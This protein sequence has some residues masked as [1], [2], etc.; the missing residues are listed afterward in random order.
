MHVHAESP[1][2]AIL[3]SFRAR[4]AQREIGGAVRVDS[5]A[6]RGRQHRAE[7]R[8]DVVAVERLAIGANEP[9]AH[10]QHRRHA[11]DDEQIA[12]ASLRHLDQ[13]PLERISVAEDG[14]G[15]LRGGGVVVD[16]IVVI[17]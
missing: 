17:A 16:R 12:R 11:G 6:Q 13:Q 9:A 1:R 5:L 2:A 8:R 4:E 14:G 10:A 3:I 15:E 7:E